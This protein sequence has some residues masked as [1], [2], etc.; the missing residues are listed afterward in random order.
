MD[1]TTLYIKG[2]ELQAPI[3]YH[4]AIYTSSPV[5]TAIIQNVLL[6]WCIKSTSNI[7][8]ILSLLAVYGRMTGIE[9]GLYV[10]THKYSCQWEYRSWVD[11][12]A[13]TIGQ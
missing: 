2:W 13:E 4:K 9:L 3:Y 6:I 7:D 10:V 12:M 1:F 11:D 8:S 5:L